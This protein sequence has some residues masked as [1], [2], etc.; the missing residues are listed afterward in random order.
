M[1]FYGHLRPFRIIKARAIF[2]IV[3]VLL[4]IISFS[5]RMM[6][7]RKGGRFGPVFQQSETL[8]KV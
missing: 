4:R 6:T 5:R 7:G 8:T 1:R 2:G 3:D